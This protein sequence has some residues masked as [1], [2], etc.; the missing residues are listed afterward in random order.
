MKIALFV[1]SAKTFFWHRKALA[2]RLVKE[3]HDVHIICSLDGEV[4][5]F[6]L[7]P[8]TTHLVSL[9][10]KG[11][12][13]FSEMF[14]IYQLY[15][16]FKKIRPD[17]CHNF[18]I[19]CVIYGSLAQRLVGVRR[20]VNSITGLGI[21]FVNGGMLQKVVEKLYQFSLN[22]SRSKVIF[23]NPD[24]QKLFIDHG[25]VQ[26]EM[27]VLIKGS[28]VDTQKFTPAEKFEQKTIIFASR[29]LKSKGILELL[30]ASVRLHSN[31][32][33]HTLLVAGEIDNAPDSIN[34]EEIERFKQ[35][36]HIKFLGNVRDIEKFMN[37]SH[38]ACFP[39]YYREGV[40]KF[41]LEAASSGLAIV[42]SD[43]PGCREVIDGN[44][45]LVFPKH[46]DL[47]VTALT[48]I[49]TNDT[50][51]E[52]FGEKS[53]EIALTRFSEEII[54]S[55]ILPLYMEKG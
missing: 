2:D 1:N 32:I 45:I 23:Q 13:P 55:E 16:L 4:E 15:L 54:L 49:L 7:E 11:K 41:L 26:P 24:D 21:V 17:V 38:I 8:Y 5:R 28:G 14:L 27:S 40:P 6:A 31:N 39:S 47:L 36:D 46:L 18:T 50:K 22:V 20:I 29:L 33:P 3:G 44:G 53:R 35:Y 43:M 10:R 51:L 52:R 25:L 30:E 37:S 42:T 19:K 48:E 9:S 34:I 12:N